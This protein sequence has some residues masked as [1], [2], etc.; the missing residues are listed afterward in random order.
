PGGVDFNNDT[1]IWSETQPGTL[2]YVAREGDLVPG[3]NYRFGEPDSGEYLRESDAGSMFFAGGMTSTS[4]PTPTNSAIFKFSPT[5]GF[6]VMATS[7]PVGGGIPSTNSDFFSNFLDPNES[8]YV[9][10]QTGP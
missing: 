1:G 3:L 8:G 7:S 4:S 2:H 9:A 6:K 10:M 5:T